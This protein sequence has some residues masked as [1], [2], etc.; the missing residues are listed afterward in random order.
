MFFLKIPFPTYNLY[1]QKHYPLLKRSQLTVHHEIVIEF[2]MNQYLV[3]SMVVL[4]YVYQTKNTVVS[5]MC[6][7]GFN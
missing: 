3:A 4:W 5:F 6:E 2:V 1:L 7:L